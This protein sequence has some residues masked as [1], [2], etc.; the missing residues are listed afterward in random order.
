MGGWVS[1]G[2][3]LSSVEVFDTHN[4]VWKPTQSIPPIAAD[5]PLSSQTRHSQERSNHSSHREDGPTRMMHGVVN[6]GERWECSTMDP[7][8]SM[9]VGRHFFAAFATT[10]TTIQPGILVAGGQDELEDVGLDGVIETR[11][12]LPQSRNRCSRMGLCV[13]D[14]SSSESSTS[15]LDSDLSGETSPGE[16]SLFFRLLWTVLVPLC[17]GCAHRECRET[18]RTTRMKRPS[19]CRSEGTTTVSQHKACPGERVHNLEKQGTL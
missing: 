2:I 1:D 12:T 7:I 9:K 15:F 6:V 19:S 8:P 11:R 17:A 10:T 18:K 4:Q 3:Y 5:W 14:S 13:E 16:T